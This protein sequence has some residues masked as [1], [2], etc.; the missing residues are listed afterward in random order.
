MSRIFKAS[1]S[2]NT[3]NNEEN[4]T[5]AAAVRAARIRTNSTQ[6]A[7]EHRRECQQMDQTKFI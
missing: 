2:N 3:S 6:E 4:K 5:E 7:I 1:T